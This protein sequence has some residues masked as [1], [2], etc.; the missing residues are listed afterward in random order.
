[1]KSSFV[2]T[3]GF[4]AVFCSAW[5]LYGDFYFLDF[6][7][8]HMSHDKFA[9]MKVKGEMMPGSLF[10]SLG[11]GRTSFLAQSGG[12]MYPIWAFAIVVPL[13]AGLRGAGA[14][15]NSAVPCAVLAYGLC[16]VGGALH[17]AFAF[18]TVLPNVY[19]KEGGW[20]E[21]EESSKFSQFVDDAQDLVI[22]HWAFGCFPGY[23]ACNIASIWIGYI[24]ATRAELTMFNR[25]FILFN[26][27]VTILWV[28]ALSGLLP[29]PWGF[30]VVGSLGS[31]APLS[32]SLGITYFLWDKPVDP[33]SLSKHFAL[34]E[35]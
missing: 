8:S 27:V 32:L 30:Y 9:M 33:F 24:V 21:L 11:N 26:P 25:W 3:C 14:I 16:V 34:K 20:P 13:Y 28:S 17:S 5:N 10:P 19:H 4:L 2:K 6:Y 22:R 7:V 12:W 35:D 31:W 18:L 1:M 15:W 29:D 23:L